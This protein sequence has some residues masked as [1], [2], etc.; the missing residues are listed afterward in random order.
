VG[1]LV[2]LLTLLKGLPSG[3][4]RD[5]QEDKEILFDTL[6][7]LEVVLPALAGALAS[8][9]FK[10]GEGG[11]APT[12]HS[13]AAELLAT[14]LADYLVRRGVPFREAHEAV[15]RA[16]RAAEEAGTPL[17]ALPLET[18]RTLHPAFGPDL[19]A[20]FSWEASVEARSLP[21]GTARR[22]VLEQFDRARETLA[23]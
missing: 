17:A 7:T 13:G 9:R 8:A 10:G 1:N 20:V 18:Y 3:Y 4:N 12:H 23:G 2:A 14:D 22:A 21:G 5:L 19:T 6:D 11:E 16:V 15:G